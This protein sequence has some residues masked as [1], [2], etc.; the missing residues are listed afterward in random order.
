MPKVS[1]CG[2]AL[3]KIHPFRRG[4]ETQFHLRIAAAG[5]DVAHGTIHVE[6]R[7]GACFEA[8][9]GVIRIDQPVGSEGLGRVPVKTPMCLQRA[10]L[11]VTNAAVVMHLVQLQIREAQHEIGGAAVASHAFGAAWITPDLPP[12]AARQTLA[13]LMTNSF[14]SPFAPTSVASD[15]F[16]SQ[17]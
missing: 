4:R 2:R 1:C 3:K 9:A 8:L 10:Q 17:R 13:S 6:I 11:V 15:W 12:A 7:T 16:S 14:S 5:F